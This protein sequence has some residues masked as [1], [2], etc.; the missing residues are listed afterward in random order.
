MPPKCN[1]C[2]FGLAA[3][4]DSWCIGCSGLELSQSLLSQRWHQPG[5]RRVAEEAIISSARLVR[6]FANLDKSGAESSAGRQADPPRRSAGRTT[7]PPPPPAPP[8]AESV[9]R[10]S[11]SRTRDN[12]PPLRRSDKAPELKPKS[13]SCPPRAEEE[14][15]YSGE[16]FEE[17][18]EEESE[19]EDPRAEVKTEG[20]HRR[21]PEP[22]VPPQGASLKPQSKKKRRRRGGKKHQRHYRE[23][24]DPLRRSHRRLRG[25]VL[26]LAKSARAG[27]ERRI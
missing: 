16:S 14:E 18:E 8:R 2:K 3:E 10:R 6:A 24:N 7:L 12:R 9:R 25:E 5:V 21:P 22:A 20:G 1:K 4:G 26:D 19:R 13:R 23:L 27:L 17:E 11:R 15:A